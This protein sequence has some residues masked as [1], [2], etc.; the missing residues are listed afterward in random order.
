MIKTTINNEYRLRMAGVAVVIAAMGAWFVYDGAIGYPQKNEAH[1]VFA[2]ALRALQE[3]GEPPKAAE[4][5]K[6]NDDGEPYIEQFAREAG[7][8]LASAKIDYVKSTQAKVEAVFN[9][10]PDKEK[11]ATKAGEIEEA[12]TQKLMEPPYNETDLN[13]QFGFAVVFFLFAALL[14]GMVTMRAR[15]KFTADD[16]GLGCNNHRF[17]YSELTNIG[18]EQWHDKHIVRFVFQKP[19]NDSI[20]GPTRLF[21]WKL[22]GWHYANVDDIVAKV[23]EH[24]KDF[25]MPEKPAKE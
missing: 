7:V 12:L 17:A 18:W 23:L 25:T 11:A 10:E 6:E 9:K 5:L 21:V 24:R 2:A 8:K 4:W 19:E 22:D 13:T 16:E 1:T 20:D 14:V 15:V 3:E